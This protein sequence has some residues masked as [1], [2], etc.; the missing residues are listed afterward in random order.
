M[1]GILF[2]KTLDPGSV[3]EFYT[4]RIGMKV[5][6]VQAHCIILKHDNFLLGFCAGDELDKEGLITFFYETRREIDEMH[7]KLKD[8]AVD[9]PKRNDKFNIYHFFA[10]DPEGRKLEFQ[11]FEHRIEP[12]RDGEEL[13]LS[14]RSVR[15]YTTEPI[16]EILLTRILDDCSFAPSSRNCQPCYFIAVRDRKRLDRL[17]AVRGGSSAPI[18]RAPLAIAICSDPGMSGRPLEDGCIMAYHFILAAWSFDLGTCWIGGMDRDDVKDLLKVP[19]EHYVACVT[20]LGYPAEKP[21][22]PARQRVR[23]LP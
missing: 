7:A 17:A 10:T 13:L 14:R 3:K 18:G 11:T 2:H 1:S 21:D 12:Y 5:W 6:L 16:D 20:P 15:A 22:A 4:K 8:I 23:R 9:E 19:R